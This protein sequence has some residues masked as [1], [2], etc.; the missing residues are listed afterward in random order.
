MW[1]MLLT[2]GCA[3]EPAPTPAPEALPVGP[4]VLLVVLDTVRAD[5]IGAMGNHRVSTP[6]LDGLADRGRVYVDAQTPGPWT[7][8]AHASLFTGEFPWTHGAHF[9]EPTAG[10]TWTLDPMPFVVTMPRADLPTLAEKMAGAGYRT[11]SVSGNV[12]IGPDLPAMVRGFERTLYADQDAK[13]VNQAIEAMAVDDDRP[14]FLFVN[15]FGAHGPHDVVDTTP[16]AAIRALR[17]PSD[18]LAPFVTAGG[19]RLDLHRPV[20]DPPLPGIMAHSGAKHTLGT[21][22][23]AVLRGM[24]EGEVG[25]VDRMLGALLKAW[26]GLRGGDDLVA[27]TADH[28][29]YLGEHGRLGHG[30][31]LHRELTHIPMVVAGPGVFHRKERTPVTLVDLHHELLRLA[32]GTPPPASQGVQAAAWPDQHWR[33]KLGDGWSKGSVLFDESGSRFIVWSDGEIE[34]IDGSKPTDSA[35]A[36][37]TTK[38]R[39]EATPGAPVQVDEGTLNQLE[40][41][42]YTGK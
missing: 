32:L 2:I 20:G 21:E 7:W 1:W 23:L 33:E 5:A 42:G 28:G 8:P 39:L 13:V 9:A 12:L 19:T 3:S 17:T 31:S 38:A 22:D 36:R 10:Q 4:D 18:A 11:A 15:L 27:V 40:A 25:E 26:T 41:L 6:N 34:V 37:A 29:E 14:L 35:G 24:Y 30:R 16:E